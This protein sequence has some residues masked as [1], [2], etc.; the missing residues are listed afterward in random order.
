M[1]RNGYP[2]FFPFLLCF[3]PP[4][5]V[6]L[7][8]FVCLPICH[9]VWSASVFLSVCLSVFVRLLIFALLYLSFFV[10]GLLSLPVSLPVS[11]YLSPPSSPLPAPP[12]WHGGSSVIACNAIDGPQLRERRPPLPSLSLHLPL[13]LPFSSL[14]VPSYTSLTDPHPRPPYSPFFLPTTL[15]PRPQGETLLPTGDNKTLAGRCNMERRRSCESW[16]VHCSPPSPFHSLPLS[17][18]H[19]PSSWLC[20]AT[21]AGLCSKVGCELYRYRK[22]RSSRVYRL[23]DM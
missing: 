15:R 8:V 20:V 12:P 4:E 21:S 7:S 23:V 22:V 13:F 14:S 18:P 9:S 2:L 3:F 1:K 6:W 11:F 16:E 19:P 10:C 17:I 5:S